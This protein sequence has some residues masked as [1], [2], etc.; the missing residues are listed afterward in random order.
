MELVKKSRDFFLRRSVWGLA[1]KA[2]DP[3]LSI[4]RCKSFLIGLIYC[5]T[6]NV[7]VVLGVYCISLVWVYT[8]VFVPNGKNGDD[9]DEFSSR[10]QFRKNEYVCVHAFVSEY[11]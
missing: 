9:A 6:L 5:E 7:H 8:C 4:F 11:F 1:R 2:R 3:D 10:L